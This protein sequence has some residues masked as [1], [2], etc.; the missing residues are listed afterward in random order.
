MRLIQLLLSLLLL[1]SSTLF[2]QTLTIE[3]DSDDPAALVLSGIL[4]RNQYRLIDRDTVIA[5][6]ETV[7][8][9]MI[10][11]D[12]RVALEGVVEGSVAVVGGDF[13]VRP[14]AAVRGTIAVIRGG[15]Y[16]SG[17]AEVGEV[18]YLSPR[19][20]PQL[21]PDTGP[22]AVSIVAPSES[23]LEL[24]NIY[25]FGPA[26]YDRVNGLSLFWIGRLASRGDTATVS[27][28]AR[29]G[30]RVERNTV[31]GVL[32]IRYVPAYRTLI[33][34]S[35]GRATRTS[36]AWIR[37]DISNALSSLFLRSDLRDYFE[38]DEV[39]L[40]IARTPPP[41]LTAGE[42]FLIPRI[43]LRVSE[44]RSL[45]TGNPFSF[46]R[47][48]EPWRLNPGI[49]EGVLASA[50]FGLSGSWRGMSARS[51]GTAAV[52]WAPGG[53]GDFDFAQLRAYANFGMISLY[54]HQIQVTGYLQT[55]LTSSEAPLQRWTFVGGAGTLPTLETAQMRGDHALL[56]SSDYTIPLNRVHLP[57][58]GMPSLKL[59]H[60]IGGAWRTGADF[61]NL[62]QN[63]GAGIQVLL[64]EAML[65]VD[66]SERP[67]HPRLVLGTQL[68]L[69][70]VPLF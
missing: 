6:H 44:D 17:L 39:S 27:L 14:R 48:D 61:P 10:V 28:N 26:G 29:A 40:S 8:G 41:A 20:S 15:A 59:T 58:A 52:E 62:K 21:T 4:E 1:S 38:S 34:A 32:D 55:P 30:Y 37:G 11:V 16:P 25:G 68:P 63:L 23:L 46:I 13:F 57:L 9:D 31:D 69:S 56:V 24:P 43:T 36:D 22:T 5:S 33:T 51:D 50:I 65:Y 18:I 42:R 7:R 35:A 3:G 70:T 47:R 2:A 49:D 45:E 67:L 53:I 60:A 54:R 66:P 19:L 12:A 64:F